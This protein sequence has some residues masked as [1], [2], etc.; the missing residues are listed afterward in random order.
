MEEIE[1]AA[2]SRRGTAFA[3]TVRMKSPEATPEWPCPK[4]SRLEA[5]WR[6]LPSLCYDVRTFV[7]GRCGNVWTTLRIAVSVSSSPTPRTD[8]D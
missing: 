2:T 6:E 1:R 7:C 8:H 4:C 3:S 5:R